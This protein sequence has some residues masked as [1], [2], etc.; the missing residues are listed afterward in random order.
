MFDN[1]YTKY[2]DAEDFI[3]L[4][5]AQ[6]I[7][8]RLEL[9]SKLGKMTAEKWAY[10]S[11]AYIYLNETASAVKAA[12]NSVKLDKNYAYGYVRLAFAYA[13]DG[14]PFS[15]RDAVEKAELLCFDNDWFLQAFFVLI[16]DWLEESEISHFYLKKL[17][18]YNLD[19]PEY[20]FAVGLAFG[21]P[22]TINDFEQAVQYLE[23]ALDYKNYYEVIHK[24]L[25]AYGDLSD[26]DNTEL[27]LNKCL[28]FG[29]TE[30]LLKKKISLYLYKDRNDEIL[31]DIRRLYYIN[32][33]QRQA[34]IYFSTAYRNKK[35]YR[36]ALKYLKFALRSTKPTQFLYEKIA[37]VYEFLNDYENAI[38]ALKKALKFDKNDRDLLLSMSY[39]YSRLKE[40][41]LADLYADKVILLNPDDAYPFYRKGNVCC[42]LKDYETAAEMYKKA[43]EREPYDVDYYGS[44]S[45]AYSNIDK[46][47]LSL[48]YANRG[49]MVDN[50]DCY[51]HFRKG[52]ALQALGKYEDAIKSFENCIKY[53]DT[54]VDA[55]A[56]ISYCYSKLKDYKK[57]T[58][59]ANKA[60]MVN[61]EYAYA[62]Y[63]KAWGLQALG[64][65]EDA[66]ESY[67]YA[68]ELDPSD[69]SSYIGLSSIGIN[70]NDANEALKAANMAIFLDRNCGEAYYF[71][72]LALSNLGKVKEAEKNFALAKKLGY[73]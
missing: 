32:D 44:V 10:L 48:E 36:K 25:L 16:Y 38:L 59:Y 9:D 7:A 47:E 55:Y 15:S 42:D 64:K 17:L 28:A 3:N 6:R 41:E 46:T 35:D 49:I 4:V 61:K 52:W 68:L 43:V 23:K 39:C 20:N 19:T 29:E 56:N 54:F 69:S 40:H 13:R 24:L 27:Y 37:E 58:L 31:A 45:Y 30:E 14:K 57:S 5:S 11:K 65:Y 33:N 22:K 62:H 2:S 63:R 8:E 67:E 71:K 70:L 26:T 21:S 51:I 18:N 34:L 1:Y 73:T 53:D 66:K 50:T 12:K 72:S 60:I